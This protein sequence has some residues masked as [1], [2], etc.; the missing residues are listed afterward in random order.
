M[1]RA[2]ALVLPV[3]AALGALGAAADDAAARG[4]P[5]S[6]AR[7]ELHGSHGYRA[8]F[9]A[10]GSE[11]RLTVARRAEAVSSTVRYW[12]P[13]VTTPLAIESKLGGLGRVSVKFHPTGTAPYA[14]PSDEGCDDPAVPGQVGYFSGTIRF[15]GE[16]GYVELNAK[17]V[18]GRA[19]TS[20]RWTCTPP[21]TRFLGSAG[22]SS[23]TAAAVQ[24]PEPEPPI[25]AVLAAAGPARGRAFFAL[26]SHPDEAP[27]PFFAA[28][29]FEQRLGL[30]IERVVTA[31]GP[32]RSFAFEDNLS[33]AM[34]EPPAPFAGNGSF[35]RLGKGRKTWTGDL[36]V[37]LPGRPDVS[38]AGPK[39]EAQMRHDTGDE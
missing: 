14:W 11:L 13:A 7:F 27:L 31:R 26:A 10:V 29:T 12:A 5:L 15:R 32:T 38:L 23:A 19:A 36:S 16:R 22:S 6:L 34:V 3:L 9:E 4:A 8:S 2:A 39:F 33:G 37:S 21:N 30:A 28:I 35:E 17:R 24:E 25:F 18:A 20:S 1:R